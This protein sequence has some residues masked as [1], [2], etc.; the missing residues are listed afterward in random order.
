MYE[1]AFPKQE[2]DTPTLLI[3]LPKLDHNIEK[4]AA[5]AD[6]A[7]VGLRPHMKTHKCPIISQRQI[8][9][10]AIGVTC[11]KLGEAEAAAKSGISDILITNQIV[12]QRKIDRL[13]K[14]AKGADVKVLVDNRQNVVELS[15]AAREKGVE[16]GVLVEVDV[17]MGRCGVQPGEQAH[18]LVEFV[19]N[20]ESLKFMGLEGYEGHACMIPSFKERE[21]RTLEAMK[22][23]V[24]TK[25]LIEAAGFEVEIVTGG[26][27]G[28]YMITGRYPG[29]TEIEAGSYATMDKKYASV[30]G[31][32]FEPA[33]TILVTVI[34]RPKEGVA[35]ID[36]GLKAM[37]AD[38]GTPEVISCEGAVLDK[39]LSEEHGKLLLTDDANSLHVGDQVELIP[40]H[41]CT[42]INLHDNFYV[43][44]DDG[45]EAVWPISARGK[46][47]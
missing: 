27:T 2:I 8:A 4:M 21:A 18:Q 45:V 42:T 1:V 35:I 36:A 7:G 31:V 30:E 44:R 34:S 39:N 24:D 9:A 26:S 25:E 23:L 43:V 19:H 38:F 13:V 41:G 15:R 11:Q 17:G 33:L 28:T 46:F 29:V 40:T 16:L 10:G 14:L 22:L 20:H 6:N 3:D 32:D 5:F 47:A 12:G 37:S